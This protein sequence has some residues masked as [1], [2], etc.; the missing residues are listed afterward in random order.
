MRMIIYRKRFISL[1]LF[2][3]L[4]L[5]FIP[6]CKVMTGEVILK[7]V[8]SFDSIIK[9]L[10]TTDSYTLVVFDVDFVLL[11][12]K[13]LIGKPA[14]RE[15]RQEEGNSLFRKI[16]KKVGQERFMYLLSIF[17][18]Q[19]EMEL[20]DARLS[21]LVKELQAPSVKVI[22]LT[23]QPYGAC[24]IIKDEGALRLEEL[25]KIGFRF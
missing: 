17:R 23:S 25:K 1:S 8:D 4:F 24:G 6:S 7:Q 3:G 18:A 11:V 15:L 9:E 10:N 2:S 16:E 13:D 12:D 14:S 5:S 20:V 19:G 22:A 21:D